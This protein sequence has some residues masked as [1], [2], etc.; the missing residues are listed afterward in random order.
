MSEKRL[1]LVTGAARGIGRAIA[2]RLADDGWRV[3]ATDRDVAPL[4]TER[5]N[6][7]VEPLDVADRPAVAALLDRHGPPD[8]T[9]CNAGISGALHPLG[10]M[11]RAAFEAVLRVNLL[12]CFVVAQESAHRMA[13]GSAI[14][15]IASRSYLTSANAT[16]YGMTKG[17]VVGLMRA[18]ASTYRWRGIS[19]NAVS[20]GLTD[21]EILR[22]LPTDHVG[23]MAA[24][25]PGGA[26][27]DPAMMAGAVAHLASPA[28]RR[29]RGQNLLVDDGKSIGIMPW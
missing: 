22:S 21:T 29:M 14:V 7:L 27:I 28:G 23:R 4:D 25:E 5:D 11:P 15:M 20:P 2:A 13:P 9:V 1:A 3:L 10:E 18:M 12:G 16:H 19:V 24:L 26:P 17:G 6:F 8:L